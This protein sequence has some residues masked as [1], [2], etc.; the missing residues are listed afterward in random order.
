M[1]T[2]YQL[3]PTKQ[4]T[5]NTCHF[6]ILLQYVKRGGLVERFANV[7]IFATWNLKKTIS[8]T[9]SQKCTN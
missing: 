8:K 4:L 9:S 2:V 3:K 1:P 6:I 7:I 5:F